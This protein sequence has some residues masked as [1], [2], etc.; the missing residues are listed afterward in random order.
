MDGAVVQIDD[1]IFI[2]CT[3]V[4]MEGDGFFTDILRNGVSNGVSSIIHD[5]E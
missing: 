3:V 5:A 2:F 1:A 4:A